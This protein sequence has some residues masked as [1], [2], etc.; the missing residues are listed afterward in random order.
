MVVIVL[1]KQK[2]RPIPFLCMH[3]ILTTK[4]SGFIILS[5]QTTLRM[6]PFLNFQIEL[7]ADFR[8]SSIRTVGQ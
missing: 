8:A 2:N 1:Y 7:F 4:I 3:E 6:I 5:L